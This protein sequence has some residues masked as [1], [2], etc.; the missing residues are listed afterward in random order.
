MRSSVL[1]QSTIYIDNWSAG[2]TID[3][4]A[5][6]DTPHT[7]QGWIFFQY[8][9]ASPTAGAAAHDN[10]AH[11]NTICNGG[12]PPK[13]RDPCAAPVQTYICNAHIEICIQIPRVQT[14]RAHYERRYD[15]VNGSNVSGTVNLTDCSALPA[16]ARAVI[17]AAGPRASTRE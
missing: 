12:P 7:S 11:R 14:S 17:H 15:E 8:F 9:G 13:P 3:D 2:Y 5:I 16:A 1:S 4:N 6:V 10:T